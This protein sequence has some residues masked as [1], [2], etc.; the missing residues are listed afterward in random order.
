MLRSCVRSSLLS[1]RAPTQVSSDLV[2]CV[3]G[4]PL[5]Q[6]VERQWTRLSGDLYV[7]GGTYGSMPGVCE[8]VRVGGDA[9]QPKGSSMRDVADI[10]GW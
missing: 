7:C 9:V 3:E 5:P 10:V 2:G 1:M 8:D 4:A 6:H